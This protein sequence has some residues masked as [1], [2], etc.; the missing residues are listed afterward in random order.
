MVIIWLS[1]SYHM[2]TYGYHK[3]TYPDSFMNYMP[4]KHQVCQDFFLLRCDLILRKNTSFIQIWFWL[5]IPIGSM[6][7]IFTYIYHKNQP[8]VGKYTI[9]GS[10]GIVF[11]FFVETSGKVTIQYSIQKSHGASSHPWPL[12]KSLWNSL[13]PKGAVEGVFLRVVMVI[14]VILVEMVSKANI[15]IYIIY[16]IYYIYIC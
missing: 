1:Y 11:V 7:G 3:K 15:Y 6:Y 12:L 10:H 13:E 8:N 14:L 2:V 5:M 4:M 9:H 16:I